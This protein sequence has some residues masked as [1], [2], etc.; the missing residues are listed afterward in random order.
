MSDT[1]IK[2]LCRQRA[3]ELKRGPEYR[4][5]MRINA[6]VSAALGAIMGSGA[7]LCANAADGV[8]YV[9][10]VITV[11][12]SFAALFGWLNARM[13]SYPLGFPSPT[14]EPASKW[15]LGQLTQMPGDLLSVATRVALERIAEKIRC[16]KTVLLSDAAAIESLAQ[17]DTARRELSAQEEA[18]VAAFG[19]RKQ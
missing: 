14:D 16:G 18:F 11:I 8:L 9:A 5:W 7:S 3:A 6:G 4:R 2:D 1:P 15:L 10:G 12:A 19:A 13:L 17:R